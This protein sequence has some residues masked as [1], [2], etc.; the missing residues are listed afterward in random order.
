MARGQDA[1]AL[2]RAG[3]WLA[4]LA[5]AVWFLL[6]IQ[7]TLT[8]FGMAWLIAYLTR[9]VVGRLEGRRLGP[10]RSC[11]RGLAVAVLYLLLA[12]LLTLLASMT[13]PA[14]SEQFNKLLSLQQTLYHPEELAARVQELGERAIARVPEQYRAQLLERLR[15]SAG[16][17]SEAVG[18]GLTEGLAQLA[19]FLTHFATGAAVLVSALLVSIYLMLS[20]ESL[21]SS[22]V[23]MMPR[24]YRPDFRE[25]LARINQIFGGYLRATII[26][27][28]VT[29]LASLLCLWLFAMVSGAPCPYAYI[30]ALVAALVY[31]IPLF[32]ILSSTVVALVLGFLPDSNLVV[33]AEVA[34]VVFVVNLVIDR[35]IQPKLMGDAIG[36]SP[37][38]VIFAAAAGGEFLGG[39]WGMLLGIPL[40]AMTKAFLVWFHELFLRDPAAAQAMVH[41]APPALVAAGDVVTENPARLAEGEPTAALPPNSSPSVVDSTTEP[42]L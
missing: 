9:P 38:F 13:L 1:S 29:G 3:I 20:W 42:T 10:I 39:I 22:T 34:A 35:T 4:L 28:L 30:I 23:S 33:G 27:S 11:P 37:L 2:V 24:R 15:S 17:I 36:V 21:Y 6:Q 8:I 31:P 14:V 40:A 5:L 18:R 19:S 12:A 32:G 41:P 7:T 26:T 16:S 25:L